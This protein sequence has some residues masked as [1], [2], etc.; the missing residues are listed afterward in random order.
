LQNEHEWAIV[1]GNT[2]NGENKGML[3]KLLT[4]LSA[5][6]VS[7]ALSA[8]SISATI[9]NPTFSVNADS[10]GYNPGVPGN[11]GS[12]P[13]PQSVTYSYQ[14]AT[15]SGS[16]SAN[17]SSN[18]VTETSAGESVGYASESYSFEILGPNIISNIPVTATGV[19]DASSPG[20][21]VPFASANAS[22]NLPTQPNSISTQNGIVDFRQSLSLTSN[23]LYSVSL[24]AY[25]YSFGA[26]GTASVDPYFQIDPAFLT[27]NPGY[28]LDFS[29]GITNAPVSTVPLPATLPMFASALL[30]LVGISRKKSRRSGHEA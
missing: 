16:A 25:S 10:N 11:S 12:G 7:V 14:N 23:T 29:P 18:Y 13:T 21:E 30:L 3:P 26:P 17:A 22:V 15:V 20:T 8:P 24:Q 6:F 27:S 9:P 28:A 4:G 19:L 5:L 2:Y 1:H